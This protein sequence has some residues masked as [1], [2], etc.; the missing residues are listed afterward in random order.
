MKDF[1]LEI[2]K[3]IQSKLKLLDFKSEVNKAIKLIY[4]TLKKKNKII[5]SLIVRIDFQII[6]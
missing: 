5:L 4:N 3:S 6:A 2:Q 1:D